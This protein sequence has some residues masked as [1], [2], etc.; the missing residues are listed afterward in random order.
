MKYLVVLSSCFFLLLTSARNL[1][2]ELIASVLNEVEHDP[3]KKIV[4]K[5]EDT[6]T[7]SKNEVTAVS[8]RNDKRGGK[9]I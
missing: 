6:T 5:K 8:A 7:N 4:D 9:S 1:R 2:E 3:G